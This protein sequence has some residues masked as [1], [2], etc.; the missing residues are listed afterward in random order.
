MLDV[1]FFGKSYSI[2]CGDFSHALQKKKAFSKNKRIFSF[3]CIFDYTSQILFDK[4]KHFGT[5]ASAFFSAMTKTNKNCC[6]KS[7]RGEGVLSSK[8]IWLV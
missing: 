1:L 7:K 6:I 8:S 4:S 5:Y 2:V 3:F